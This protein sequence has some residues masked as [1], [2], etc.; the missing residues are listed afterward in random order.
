MDRAKKDISNAGFAE[1]FKPQE[2][3]WRK[4]M[5]EAMSERKAFG[6]MSDSILPIPIRPELAVYIQGLP[7]D[8]TEDEANKIAN[9]VKAM[10]KR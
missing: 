3:F 4:P 8:M 1:I 5:T 6:P 7:L 9:V 10:V 2:L